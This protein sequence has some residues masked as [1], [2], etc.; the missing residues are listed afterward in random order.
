[1][2]G[3]LVREFMFQ[4]SITIQDN[5][6]DS[7]YQHVHHARALYFLERARLGFLEAVGYPTESY[8]RQGLFWV[9]ASISAQYKRELR[10]GPI[11]VTCERPQID[12]KRL[13]LEQRILNERGKVAVEGQAVSMLLS[14]AT[15]RSAQIPEEFALAVKEFEAKFQVRS[16]SST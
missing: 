10:A 2:D 8:M 15:G 16:G 1:M 5:D 11:T 12:G 13:V 9:I 3:A 7:V 14:K 6:L 4:L